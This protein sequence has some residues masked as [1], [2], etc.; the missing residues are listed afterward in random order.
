MDTIQALSL[1]SEDTASKIEIATTSLCCPIKQGVVVGV[2]NVVEDWSVDDLVSVS[3]VDEMEEIE[4]GSPDPTEEADLNMSE[5][6]QDPSQS[7]EPFF[8]VR[9]KESLQDNMPQDHFLL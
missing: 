9:W 3:D 6:I 1:I 8:Y 2:E 5:I 7:G 4:N